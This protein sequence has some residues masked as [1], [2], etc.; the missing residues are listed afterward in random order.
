MIIVCFLVRHPALEEKW[1][2][3]ASLTPITQ[4]TRARLTLSHT[5]VSV[6]MCLFVCVFQA[7]STEDRRMGGDGKRGTCVKCVFADGVCG[8]ACGCHTTQTKRL[9]PVADLY[10]IYR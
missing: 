6:C 1:A 3:S 4:T 9:L 10:V 7:V 8:C 5:R 2:R